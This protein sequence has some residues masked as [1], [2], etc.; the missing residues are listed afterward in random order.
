[1]E[2]FYGIIEYAINKCYYGQFSREKKETDQYAEEGA[3]SHSS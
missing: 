1:M 3:R 2:A